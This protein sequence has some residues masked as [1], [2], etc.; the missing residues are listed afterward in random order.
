MTSSLKTVAVSQS[1]YIPW[2]GYFDLI[3]SADEFV[4][5]DCVQFTRR[6]WRNR[7]KIKTPNALIWLTVP[8]KV[9]GK[10]NQAIKDVE[11]EK[12]IWKEEHWKSI[13]LN[14][15]R[16]K[17]FEE[18]SAWLKPLYLESNYKNLSELNKKFI[19]EI[20]S[21]LDVK[22]KII[23]SNMF[24]TSRDKSQRILDIVNQLDGDV[25]LSGPSAKAYINIENF[26]KNNIKIKWMKYENYPIYDQLWGKF[27]NNVS[28]IDLLFNCGPKSSFFINGKN[29]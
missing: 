20:C 27:E 1:N 21:Y 15:K 14:Y 3:A 16:S 7:N 12:E 24:K 11:I 22:T 29:N 25:Y 8:V 18:I 13:E 19:L 2:K 6:D 5:L 10:Y 23:D 28:I 4:I 9:K 26:H 17:Y